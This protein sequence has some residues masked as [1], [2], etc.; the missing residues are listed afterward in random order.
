MKTPQKTTIV[1]QIHDGDRQWFIVD[2]AEHTIGTLSVSIANALRGKHRVDFTPHM[3]LGNNVIVLNA[4][5]V[6]VTGRKEYQKTYYSH[7][8]YVGSLK[9]ESLN[10][11]RKKDPK[12]I[13]REAVS[14]MLTRTKHRK[15]Q[16]KRL[17]LCTDENHRFQAQKPMPLPFITQ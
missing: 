16:M 5:K 12:R 3:D 15:G 8:G 17:H 10:S 9:E 14:G 1:T 4:G 7:S 13:L 6:K 2:A 11:L